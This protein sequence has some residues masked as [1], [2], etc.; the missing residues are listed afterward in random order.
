VV[1]LDIGGPH[2]PGE[3]SL[4][5][6]ASGGVRRDDL[7]PRPG[8]AVLR[9]GGVTAADAAP[10]V[11]ALVAAHPTVVLRL[12]PRPHP[13]GV[14]LPV[15]PVRLLLPGGWFPWGGHPA[16]YQATPAVARMPGVG[17]RL[18]IPRPAT[19]ESLLRGRRPLQRDRWVAAWRAAWGFPWGR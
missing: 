9:N 11:S 19:V 2:Y 15:V 8:I 7:I 5:E 18:P 6:M 17:V 3:R 4:A 14:G 12:P 16:V 10:V 13:D 1:D